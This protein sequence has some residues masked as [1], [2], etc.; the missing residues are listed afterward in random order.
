MSRA[1]EWDETGHNRVTGTRFDER[2]YTKDGR[3]R[4]GK[5]SQG[6]SPGQQANN[7]RAVRLR[8][9]AQFEVERIAAEKV[10]RVECNKVAWA[11]VLRMKK[12]A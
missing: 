10:A 4:S 9:R 3:H 12:A 6:R 7:E 11:A 5:D 2:G 8:E 1:S